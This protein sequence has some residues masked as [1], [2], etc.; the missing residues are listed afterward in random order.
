MS[1]VRFSSGYY[2]TTWEL[3]RYNRKNLPSIVLRR[4]PEIK[5]CMYA[6]KRNSLN[7]FKDKIVLPLKQKILFP[8]FYFQNKNTSNVVMFKEAAPLMVR[9]KN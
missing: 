9:H 1:N 2:Y 4:N 3:P 6:M 7:R 5:I 8:A